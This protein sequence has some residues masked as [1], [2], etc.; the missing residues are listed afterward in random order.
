MNL[1]RTFY[2]RLWLPFYRWYALRHV[3]QQQEW[4]SHGL[5][6]EVPPGV[7]HPG[8]YFSTPIFLDYLGDL[9]FQDK[10]VL[11]IGTGSG[12]LG[13]FVA[14]KGASVYALD[15]NPIA[16]ETA[17][18]NA[19]L[20]GVPIHLFQSDLFQALPPVKADYIL[21]NPPYYPRDPAN[22]TEHAFF[23]GEGLTYF[24]RFFVEV[25]PF[26]Q[27]ETSILMI[28]SEDCDWMAI[29]RF[30]AQA[31]FSNQVVAEKK[32]WGELLFVGTFGRA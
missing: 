9:D 2:R 21:V 10:T 29:R 11:D 1:E 7:F 4:L 26:C 8:I 3:E 20:S 17:R 30:A 18:R 31:G 27:A 13:I 5:A 23:A 19:L 32:H 14:K 22:D 16:V 25:I 6:L 15:I 12:V 24:Q 28:L